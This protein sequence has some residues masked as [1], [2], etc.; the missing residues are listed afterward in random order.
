MLLTL[1]GITTLVSLLHPSNAE[2]L[3]SVTLDEIDRL[4]SFLQSLN[5][6]VPIMAVVAVVGDRMSTFSSAPHLSN[7]EV[8]MLV[9]VLGISTLVISLH[10]RN[11]SMPM[12]RTVS[13]QPSTV[14]E[15]GIFTEP[16]GLSTKPVIT[17]DDP[18]TENLK[19][20]ETP[21]ESDTGT[22]VKIQVASNQA[23]CRRNREMNFSNRHLIGSREFQSRR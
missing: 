7:A 4:L 10:P 6:E 19:F 17:I 5:A 1:P 9:T 13:G 18:A 21:A 8:W 14:I 20:P 16:T 3:M 23:R 2:V 12:E 11:A 22:H 15:E